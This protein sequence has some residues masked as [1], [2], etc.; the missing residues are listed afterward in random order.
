[1]GEASYQEAFLR[2]E[3]VISIYQCDPCF[4]PRG[5]DF[6]SDFN[7]TH[8]RIKRR[9]YAIEACVDW[10]CRA[11]SSW[12]TQRQ[13]ICNRIVR[14]DRIWQVRRYL[15]QEEHFYFWR[16]YNEHEWHPIAGNAITKILRNMERNNVFWE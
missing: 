15:T 1:M 11:S 10:R 9:I 5:Q 13:F 6:E 7:P 2:I 8:D 12:W 14:V 4:F 3:R 16:Y